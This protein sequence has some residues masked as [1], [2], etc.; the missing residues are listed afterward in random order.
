MDVEGPSPDRIGL[1]AGYGQFPILF[2][3]N[4]K[5]NG[6]RVVGFGIRHEASPE[7]EEHVE[8]LHWVGVARVGRLI[9]LL[10]SEGIRHA[11]M[12]GKVRKTVMFAPFRILRLLPDLRTF[13]LWFRRVR[14]KRDD[15]LLGAVADELASEGIRLESSLLYCKDL[16]AAEGLLA[17]KPPAEREAADIRFGWKLAKAMGGLDVGQSVSV[18]EQAVLAVEAIEGTDQAILRAG[19]LG[20][21]GFVVVKVSKPGQDPRFDVPAIG[22]D[23]I[24]TM[25]SAGGKVLAVEAGATLVLGIEETLS[26]AEKEGITVVGLR[27]PAPG[28]EIAIP[29]L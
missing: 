14:D 3:K 17:G 11:V 2:A 18:K 1:I 19:S 9:R 21:R 6:V 12:A 5:T 8:R 26:L 15:T 7:L 13:R 22:P 20:R 16:L 24:R 10:K 29:G 23:T 27:D 4:A 25:A 28:A